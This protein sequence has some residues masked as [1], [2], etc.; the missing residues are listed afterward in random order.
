LDEPFASLDAL[1]RLQMQ[2]LVRSL[3]AKFTPATIIVT[4]DVEEALLLADRIVLLRDGK[5]AFEI[6][7]TMPRPRSLDGAEFDRL[8]R[9]LLGELGVHL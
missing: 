9:M 4:H 5:F 6:E 7:V 8:R 1:T 2:D 3:I